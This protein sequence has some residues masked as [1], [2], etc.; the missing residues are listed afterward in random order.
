MPIYDPKPPFSISA[1]RESDYSK[2]FIGKNSNI[3]RHETEKDNDSKEDNDN[4]PA[5]KWGN[6][7]LTNTFNP[8]NTDSTYI[9]QDNVPD[10]DA[11]FD[12]QEKIDINFT[13]ND[14][15]FEIEFT[16]DLEEEGEEELEVRANMNCKVTRDGTVVLGESIFFPLKGNEDFQERVQN[17]R[18]EYG[19]LN[20][21]GLCEVFDGPIGIFRSGS[22]GFISTSE[23]K[24][25][26]MIEL[27]KSLLEIALFVSSNPEK[28]GR[29]YLSKKSDA[30][31]FQKF[32]SDSSKATFVYK[33][34]KN[35]DLEEI[36]GKDNVVVGFFP[37]DERFVVSPPE[38]SMSD[39]VF[40]YNTVESL[41]DQF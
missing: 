38:E 1:T 27:E 41:L 39:I 30:L 22:L 3:C 19:H 13:P 7:D 11:E 26:E 29:K 16:G 14:Y 2:Q 5:I 31:T 37:E 6:Q 36:K 33:G 32:Q 17:I 12:D 28:R 23:D 4:E 40:P 20:K 8:W 10:I 15:T 21:E 9:P 18:E 24:D 25:L 34:S 35:D